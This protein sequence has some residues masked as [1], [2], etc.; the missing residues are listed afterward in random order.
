VDC[1]AGQKRLRIHSETVDMDKIEPIEPVF[2]YLFARL[3][4]ELHVSKP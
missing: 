1:V 2:I 3:V 4:L